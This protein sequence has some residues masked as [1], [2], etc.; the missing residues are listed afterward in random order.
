MNI[1]IRISGLLSIALAMS[2]AQSTPA[3]TQMSVA[4]PNPMGSACKGDIDCR[5]GLYCA[6]DD[7]GGECTKGCKSNTDCGAGLICGRENKCYVTCASSTSCRRGYYA[8]IGSGSSKYCD[9]D[10]NALYF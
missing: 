3:S 7:L 8:C 9:K 10:P 1:N 2:C 6:T 4:N 5:A